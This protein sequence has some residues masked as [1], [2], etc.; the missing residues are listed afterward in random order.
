MYFE[1]YVKLSV[2][3]SMG[4]FVVGGDEEVPVSTYSTTDRDYFDTT[5][6][7]DNVATS[8]LRKKMK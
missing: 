3:V 8:R 7:L 6:C 5:W 4:T 2:S 1:E